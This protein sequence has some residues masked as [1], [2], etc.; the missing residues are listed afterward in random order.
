MAGVG[1]H[2]V[3]LTTLMGQK[4]SGDAG[5]DIVTVDRSYL[6]IHW[7]SLSTLKKVY[8]LLIACQSD[9]K[10]GSSSNCGNNVSG[11]NQKTD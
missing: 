6:P 9:C 3:S 11:E 1:L 4:R 2:K 7:N 8:S 5:T 10:R